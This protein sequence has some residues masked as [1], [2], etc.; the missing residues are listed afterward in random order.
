MLDAV[1]F[2]VNIVEVEGALSFV[3]TIVTIFFVNRDHGT[4]IG[5]VLLWALSTIKIL[6]WRKILRRDQISDTRRSGTYVKQSASVYPHLPLQVMAALVQAEARVGAF[7]VLRGDFYLKYSTGS[8]LAIVIITDK[9][10]NT[11]MIII[12]L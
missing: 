5:T 2:R 6:D 1:A 7:A 3:T 12:I 11:F 9:T 4:A 8:Q 10:E